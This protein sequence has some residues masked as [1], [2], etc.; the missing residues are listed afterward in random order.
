ML[1]NE[2]KQRQLRNPKYSIRA[3]A[4]DIDFDSAAVSR[5]LR[6]ELALTIKSASKIAAKL[7]ITE[8]QKGFL[9]DEETLSVYL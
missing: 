3:F 6:N 4:R 8:T 7:N 9:L 1:E 2:L 5:V